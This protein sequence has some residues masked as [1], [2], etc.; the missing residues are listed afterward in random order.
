M[1]ICVKYLDLRGSLPNLIM[2]TL[3]IREQ[4]HVSVGHCDSCE[5][6]IMFYLM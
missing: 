5:L 4:I 2:L 6:I 3:M 1:R